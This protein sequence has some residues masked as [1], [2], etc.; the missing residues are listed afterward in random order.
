MRLVFGVHRSTRCC[1]LYIYGHGPWR[2][3]KGASIFPRNFFCRGNPSEDRAQTDSGFFQLTMLSPC[4]PDG[5]PLSR[6]VSSQRDIGHG[7][8][9]PCGYQTVESLVHSIHR[10]FYN[11][12][13]FHVL[14][15]LTS[16]DHI[17]YYGERLIPSKLRAME[18]P[19]PRF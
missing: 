14:R 17:T 8:V 18:W 1:G 6:E 19:T 7:K 13:N 10:A 15:A 5:Y 11:V 3:L 16:F 4:I 9:N 2:G 12:R